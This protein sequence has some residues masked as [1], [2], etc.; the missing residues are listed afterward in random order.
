[1]AFKADLKA[2]LDQ[3]PAAPFLFAGAGLSRRYLGL[4]GWEA[5]L[6]RYAEVAGK[7]FEYCAASADGDF[8][9]I[10]SRIAA[11]LH[12]PWWNDA[13]FEE[14][15]ELYKDLVHG[16]SISY[17]SRSA[18]RTPSCP[19]CTGGSPPSIT[20]WNTGCHS[21]SGSSSSSSASMSPR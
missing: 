13:A 14:S 19:T 2:H 3:L 5:L 6:R 10:A 12:E 7:P 1:M 16:A 9:K 15:R 17:H 20:T 11:D 8:P 18:S 21:T 4:D